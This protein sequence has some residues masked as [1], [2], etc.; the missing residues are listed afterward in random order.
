MASPAPPFPDVP[1]PPPCSPDVQAS[2]PDHLMKEILLRIPTTADLAWASMILVVAGGYLLLHGFPHDDPDSFPSFEMPELN[3]F[4]LNLQTMKVERFCW[5]D[6]MIP[7]RDHCMLISRHPCLHQLFEGA[8]S[9]FAVQD[10]RGKLPVRMAVK[11]PS[12]T[13]KQLQVL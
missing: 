13:A 12:F 5:S 9:C 6:H 10:A 1:P 4:S 11:A 3:C 2:L 8:E 7:C